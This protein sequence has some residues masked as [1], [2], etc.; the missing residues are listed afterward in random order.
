MK[1]PRQKDI[2]ILRGGWDQFVY[3]VERKKL[4]G[5][6]KKKSLQTRISFDQLHNRFKYSFILNKRTCLYADYDEIANWCDE[7]IESWFLLCDNKIGFHSKY[8]QLLF[9][10][11]Y[12]NLIS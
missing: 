10:L 8:D 5:Q 6:K 3:Q 1:L 4:T 7:Y 12:G 9:A 2:W 11:R